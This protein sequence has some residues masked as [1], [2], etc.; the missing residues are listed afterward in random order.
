MKSVD[1]KEHSGHVFRAEFHIFHVFRILFHRC[2]FLLF[3]CLYIWFPL[4]LS[5]SVVLYVTP[6]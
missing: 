1:M 5:G 4:F 2:G 3:V 6:F